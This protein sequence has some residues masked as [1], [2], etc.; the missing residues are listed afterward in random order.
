M[1]LKLKIKNTYK[2]L[3]RLMRRKREKIQVNKIRN[4]R[5]DITT[6]PTQVQRILRGYCEQLLVN[7]LHTPEEMDRPLKHTLYQY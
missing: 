1:K 4:E 3:A 6:D 7:N 2:T 5:G